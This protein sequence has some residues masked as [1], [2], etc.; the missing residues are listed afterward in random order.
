MTPK[1]ALIALLLSAAALAAC[2]DL[3]TATSD[4]PAL[5]KG[6]KPGGGDPVGGSEVVPIRL[7]NLKDIGCSGAEAYAI[8]SAASPLV[9]GIGYGCRN[10]YNKPF[11]WSAATGLQPTGSSPGDFARAVSDNGLIVG[12]TRDGLI[13]PGEFSMAGV[14]RLLPLPAGFTWGDP[15]GVTPDGLVVVGYGGGWDIS[16]VLRWQRS[17]AAAAW[18]PAEVIGIGGARGVSADGN[19]II[20]GQSGKPAAWV[21]D[22][23]GWRLDLLDTEK[24]VAN[25]VDR[26]GTTA[27]GFRWLPSTRDPSILHD[28][29]TAWTRQPDGSWTVETLRGADPAFDEG[30]AHSVATQQDG[31]TV[32]VGFAWENTSGPGGTQWALAWRRAPGAGG[33]GPPVRLQPVSSTYGAVAYGV[34]TQGEVV[35]GAWTGRG[36]VPVMWRLPAP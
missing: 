18:P 23:G 8:S 11:I 34:N 20:G 10:P 6:G 9:V 1:L 28:V 27:V 13:V 17:S 12:P 19:L 4:A 14:S 3:P 21:R 16:F 36:T 22:L 2:A 31:S 7:G 5:A 26:A 30:E 29:P 35:G 32:A 24:G 25:A 33:F 15:T